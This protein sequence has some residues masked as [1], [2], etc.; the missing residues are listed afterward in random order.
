MDVSKTSGYIVFTDGSS[1]GNPGP[2][3]YGAVIIFPDKKTVRELGGKK[4]K[5][6]NNE[7][8]LT[9]VAQALHVC[10][11]RPAPASLFVDSEYVVKGITS[12]VSSWRKNGWRTK[13]KK[14]V[15]HRELWEKI[16]GFEE[17]IEKAGYPVTWRHV[18]SHVGVPGN[19]RCD[20]IAATFAEGKR[21]KLHRGTLATYRV[22]NVLTVAP[23]RE[24][25]LTKKSARAV[26]GKAYSYL[27]LVDGVF[28]KHDTWADCEKRVKGKD[29]KF[30]K[31][32]SAEHEEEIMRDWGVL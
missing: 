28:M 31:A 20:A 8:E 6:T 14:T 7:M 15:S 27:S 25:V 11:S 22:K 26:K 9:A 29:A 17:K 21:P 30:R 24:K 13:V 4:E 16:K 2:G 18:T 3:G 10:A 32:L 5:T 12:W 23:D 19:E 1:L